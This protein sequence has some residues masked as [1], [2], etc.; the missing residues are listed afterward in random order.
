LEYSSISNN[1]IASLDF[2]KNLKL[3]TILIS[4]SNLI[5]DINVSQNT[6]LENLNVFRLPNLS[7]IY[8]KNGK[9][10]NFGEGFLECPKLSYVCCDE[11]E[12]AYFET[13]NIQTIVTDCLLSTQENSSLI[14]F[15]IYPNPSS[16]YLNFNQKVESI[17]I[18][19][20]QGK[21]VLYKKINS[22]NLNISEL[23]NGVYVLEEFSENKRNSLKFIKK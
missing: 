6:S 11:S 14:D 15:K 8:I 23:R 5:S 13:K 12:R 16:D 1:K 17:K 9:Q 19:D 18:F 4:D 22:T 7:R 2:S 10:Q 20:I 3:K 21:L